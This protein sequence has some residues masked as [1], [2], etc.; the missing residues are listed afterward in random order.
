LKQIIRDI[1]GKYFLGKI[2]RIYSKIVV[3]YSKIMLREL[4]WAKSGFSVPAPELVKRGCLTRHGFKDAT[5]IETGTSWGETTEFLSKTANRV[6]TIEPEPELFRKAQRRFAD[7]KNVEIINGLSE[8]VLPVLLPTI[9]GTVN[10]WLD[11]HYSEGPTHL[12][13]QETPI[14]DELMAITKNMKNFEGVCVM[15]D[16]LRLF[17]NT[18]SG[19]HDPAYPDIDVLVNWARANNLPWTIEQDIFIA[20]S[21][22]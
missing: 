17:G 21:V 8:E 7:V 11:G 20:K 3:T 14:V 22:V 15:V 2:T 6:I 12:G 9:R 10:F 16:D 18:A 1:D 5:W 4:P 13:P 19:L